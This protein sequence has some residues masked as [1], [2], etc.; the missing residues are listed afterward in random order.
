MK[1]CTFWGETADDEQLVAAIIAGLK[2]ATCEP[3]VWAEDPDND[4][5]LAAVGEQVAV[6][7]KRGRHLCTIEIAESCEVKFGEV[8]DRLVRG[9]GCRDLDHFAEAHRT[10]W[11][12]DLKREGRP[13]SDDTVLSAQNS[14]LVS[15]QPAGET[16]IAAPAGEGLGR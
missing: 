16:L 8:D 2:T 6:M 12:K 9:E 14:R 3:K 1:H 15:G 10:A 7:S 13:L 4:E 5:E 11:G